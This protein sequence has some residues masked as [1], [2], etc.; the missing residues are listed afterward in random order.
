MEAGNCSLSFS[1]HG[2]IEGVICIGEK[3][4]EG[5]GFSSFKIDEFPRAFVGPAIAEGK[6]QNGFTV[7]NTNEMLLE[8]ISL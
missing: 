8:C 3:E 6:K 4:I 2:H 7:L 5:S 1:G